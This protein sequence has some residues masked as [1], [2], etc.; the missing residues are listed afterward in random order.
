MYAKRS[1]LSAM[2]TEPDVLSSAASADIYSQSASVSS[3]LDALLPPRRLSPVIMPI[4]EPW[5]RSSVYIISN[6]RST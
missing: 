2:A 3:P 4:A 5:K 6:A 1:S